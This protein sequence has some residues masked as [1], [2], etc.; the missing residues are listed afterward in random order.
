MSLVNASQTAGNYTVQLN[1]T[2]IASGVYFY[3]LIASSNGTD[4][5]ITKKM[6]VIK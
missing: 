2:N 1:A 3:R 6:N 5:V 4:N